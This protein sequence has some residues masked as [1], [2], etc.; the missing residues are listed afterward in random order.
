MPG[1]TICGLKDNAPAL[2]WRT[3]TPCIRPLLLLVVAMA[4]KLVICCSDAS[5]HWMMRN[6]DCINS[7]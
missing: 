3:R 7:S 6:P 5:S 4:C 2:A 1:P